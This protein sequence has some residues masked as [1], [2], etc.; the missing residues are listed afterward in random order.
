MVVTNPLFEFTMQKRSG[1]GIE[2]RK[3][4]KTDVSQTSADR[5]V[6]ALPAASDSTGFLDAAMAVARG[7]IGEG[8]RSLKSVEDRGGADVAGG[9]RKLI[10]AMQPAARGHERRAVQLLQ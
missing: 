1:R 3:L 5:N 8:E 6:Q 4:R 9:T 2:P 10:A 7:A